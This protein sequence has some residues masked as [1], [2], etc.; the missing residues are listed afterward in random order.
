MSI[1][2]AIPALNL[3]WQPRRETL[4]CSLA[5]GKP[6]IAYM[7]WMAPTVRYYAA[8][9]RMDCLL[10][11]LNEGGLVPSRPAAW[12]KVV[13]LNHM[14]K[15]YET[16]IWLD[17]DTMIVNP[18]NDIR[19]ELDPQIPMHVV[20]HRIGRK[21]IPN[22]GVWVCRNDPRTFELLESVWSHTE[23]IDD[24]W[25]EQAALMDLI[26]YEPRERKCRFRGP[27]PYTSYVRF[28]DERWNSR[29]AAPAPQTN[30]LHYSGP[31]KS[32]DDMERSYGL[33]LQ[34]I[35]KHHTLP[36]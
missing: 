2:S 1:I 11:P 31:D 18:A 22:T 27:T 24:G 34:R 17:A 6:H 15:G 10:L 23:F 29:F 25:W 16:V 26:G 13:L 32:L 20:A 35:A 36:G 33:F 12:N 14:L 28:L 21:T 5:V 3:S 9:H 30:I 19:P 4:I 8:R 7:R